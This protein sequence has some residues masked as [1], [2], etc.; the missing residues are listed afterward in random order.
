M[1]LLIVTMV[2]EFQPNAMKLL[3]ESHIDRFSGFE[4]DGFKEIPSALINS[5]WFPEEK[6]GAKSVLYFSFT[7]EDKIDAFLES[8][9]KFNKTLETDNPIKAIVVPIEKY[10]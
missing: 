9:E 8:A 3:K 1:K 2:E 5:S 7:S 10:L 4:I 6:A